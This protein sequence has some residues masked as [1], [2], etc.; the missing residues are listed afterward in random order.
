MPILTILFLAG[1]SNR[2]GFEEKT[3]RKSLLSHVKSS[4][5]NAA[6]YRNKIHR[7]D[8]GLPSPSH[9]QKCDR[10]SLELTKSSTVFREGQSLTANK[11]LQISRALESGSGQGVGGSNPLSPTIYFQ[12]K[13]P[14]FELRQISAEGKSVTLACFPNICQQ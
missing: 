4:K 3:C 1:K 11:F 7:N 10:E 6:R 12:Q 9:R 13:L 2:K 5:R 14:N 8:E